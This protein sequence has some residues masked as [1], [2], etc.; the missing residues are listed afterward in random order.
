MKSDTQHKSEGRKRII[1]EEELYQTIFKVLE[2]HGTLVLE[3]PD[4]VDK[5]ADLIAKAV[6]KSL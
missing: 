5:L 3:D 1:Y 6:F 4:N 2:D